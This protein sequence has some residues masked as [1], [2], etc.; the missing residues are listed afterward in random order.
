VIY[1]NCPTAF[2]GFSARTVG[3][4]GE[5]DRGPLR[6]VECEERDFDWQISRDLSGGVYEVS[7]EPGFP[8]FLRRI[9][10][11]TG[12]PRESAE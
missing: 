3:I 4:E 6:R 11:L 8:A 12:E 7:A 2:D 10:R 5:T 9:D 1:T